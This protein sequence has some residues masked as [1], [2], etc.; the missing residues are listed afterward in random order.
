MNCLTSERS[1]VFY[2]RVIR[3]VLESIFDKSNVSLIKTNFWLSELS[4][5]CA[6]MMVCCA[7]NLLYVHKSMTVPSWGN[8]LEKDNLTIL[9]DGEASRK[10]PLS[11]GF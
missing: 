1:L 6:I 7:T 2:I 5:H 9:T 10:I 4:S 3:E 8:S 11:S